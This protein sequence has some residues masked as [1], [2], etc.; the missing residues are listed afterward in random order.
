MADAPEIDIEALHEAIK[1]A[2]NARFDGVTVDF[3]ARPGGKAGTP[4]I[5]F[6]L[7]SIEPADPDESGTEQFE[8]ILRFAA[9][10]VR[11]YKKEGEVKAKLAARTLAAGVMQFV[12]GHRWDQPVTQ[13]VLLGAFPDTFE[14][15]ID[16]YEVQRVEWEHRGLI[17][18]SVWESEGD[19]P[20]EVYVSEPEA[21]RIDDTVAPP[22]PAPEEDAT[23]G[24]PVSEL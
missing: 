9:Y 7:E 14:Q 15:E 20:T 24:L 21:G 4:G 22:L 8:A 3:Y 6:E 5:Y 12:R 13:A 23:P 10:V 19:P 18:E 2:L 17:G 1:T 11:S 16:Q